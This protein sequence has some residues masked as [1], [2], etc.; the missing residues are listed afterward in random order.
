MPLVYQVFNWSSGVDAGA[1]MGSEMTGAAG[2]TGGRV[3]RDPM[4]MLPFCGYNMGDYFRHWMSMQR[5]L[6]EIPRIC[7][8]DWFRLSTHSNQ[9]AITQGPSIR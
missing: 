3:R 1:T 5:N 8:V 9:K 2:G 6:S 7:H 4:A